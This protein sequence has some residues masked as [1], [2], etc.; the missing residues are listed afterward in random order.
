MGGG[1]RVKW[2]SDLD[3]SAIVSNFEK[4]GWVKGSLEG[5]ISGEYDARDITCCFRRW[6]LE[7]LLLQCV[8]GQIHVQRRQRLQTGG[9]PVR[10]KN[11]GME[12]WERGNG[13]S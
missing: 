13:R 3:K 10:I 9:R 8:H 7:F 11:R 5:M 6:G 12:N 1:S 2:L 4:R